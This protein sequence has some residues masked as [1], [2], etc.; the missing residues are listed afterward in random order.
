MRRTSLLLALVAA[1]CLAGGAGA[2]APPVG[3]LPKGPVTSIQT[4]KGQLVS[5]ALPSRAGLS[6]RLARGVD[7]KVLVQVSEANVGSSVV[8]V[9]RAVGKGAVAVKYGQT[10]GE[11]TKAFAS[12]TFNVRVS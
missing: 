9:Y 4:T 11:T 8:V 2:G 7:A 1:L 10:R 5:V 12:A 6:W 3:A